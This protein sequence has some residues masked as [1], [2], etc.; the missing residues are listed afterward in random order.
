MS[1]SLSS[2]Y[3]DKMHCFITI[4]LEDTSNS[5][6]VARL[7]LD[8]IPRSITRHKHVLSAE[9]AAWAVMRQ[10]TDKQTD[11][12][13]LGCVGASWYAT[14]CVT[15]MA[16][17]GLVCHSSIAC[18]L[19]QNGTSMYMSCKNDSTLAVSLTRIQDSSTRTTCAGCCC[20]CCCCC[21]C[22]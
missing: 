14:Y 6:F 17:T 12:D 3:S 18:S 11:S 7:P 19:R 9:T 20:C 10:Q 16:V 4:P 13:A 21:C 2:S 5:Y 22:R 8:D 1:P 15:R